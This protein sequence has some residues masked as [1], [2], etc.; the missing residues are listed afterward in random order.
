[1]W[2]AWSAKCICACRNFRHALVVS[3]ER[4]RDGERGQEHSGRNWLDF[5][6]FFPPLFLLLLPLQTASNLLPKPGPPGNQ[7]PQDSGTEVG[8]M[9]LHMMLDRRRKYLGRTLINFR[10]LTNFLWRLLLKKFTALVQ[11]Q[12]SLKRALKVGQLSKGRK[13]EDW[14]GRF[15]YWWKTCIFTIKR[16]LYSIDGK[17]K[18]R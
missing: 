2:A 5:F 6:F 11:P 16:V 14:I 4:R 9:S 1:M 7:H 18:N 3:A 8:K 15:S 12:H 10:F 13:F 17:H